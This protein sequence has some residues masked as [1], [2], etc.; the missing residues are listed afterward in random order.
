MCIFEISLVHW[1][2]LLFV[3]ERYSP[4]CLSLSCTCSWAAG[5]AAAFRFSGRVVAQ[6]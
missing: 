6:Q 1:W 4:V 3:A 5:L 2:L